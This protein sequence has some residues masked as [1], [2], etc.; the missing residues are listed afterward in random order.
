MKA[1]AYPVL[2]RSHANWQNYT[3]FL[4]QFYPNLGL[5]V[6]LLIQKMHS[7]NIS[8]IQGVS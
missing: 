1:T 5:T 4:R 8:I 2:S 7:N 3:K 6:M